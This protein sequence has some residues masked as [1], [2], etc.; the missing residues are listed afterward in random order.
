MGEGSITS[1]GDYRHLKIR[2]ELSQSTETCFN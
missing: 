2:A 1:T